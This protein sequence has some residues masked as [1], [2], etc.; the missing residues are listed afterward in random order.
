MLLLTVVAPVFGT[1]CYVLVADDEVSCVVVDPGGGTASGV[2]SVVD[3]HGLRPVAVLATH[4]HVDH[5]WD[6]ARLSDRYDVDLHLH[7][8]DAYRLDDPFGTLGA[9]AAGV[10]DPSGPL[11]QALTGAGMPPSGYRRPGRVRPFRL[12]MLPGEPDLGE[13]RFGGAPLLALHAPGHTEGATVYLVAG[14]PGPGS[15]LPDSPSL[16][17][18]LLGAG[19]TALTGDVLFAGTIGRTDLPGG[20]GETMLTTLRDRI[21]TLEPSTLVLPGHGPASRMDLEL[22]TNAFLAG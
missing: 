12:G 6:A 15:V 3:R 22:R 7:A 5:T 18:L 1:N 21:S 2:E 19:G 20:D 10:H 17:T 16:S 9:L 13:V 14:A 8:A 11:A 4:G